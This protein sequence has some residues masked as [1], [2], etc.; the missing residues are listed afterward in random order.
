M[1]IDIESE[2][3]G[4]HG[5]YD[6]VLAVIVRDGC[7]QAFLGG[8]FLERGDFAQV[9]VA[10]G[11]LLP[12]M[13]EEMGVPFPVFMATLTAVALKGIPHEELRDVTREAEDAE[14]VRAL[15]EEM[16]VEVPE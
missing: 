13:A 5:G 1:K 6:R 9:A 7:A 4:L 12:R 15:A 2:A 10:V 11:S 3:L 16:G 8:A 14:A